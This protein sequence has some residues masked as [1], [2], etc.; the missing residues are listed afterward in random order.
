ML[1][2]APAKGDDGLYFVRVTNDDKKKC[3]VQLNKVKVTGISGAEV[4]IDPSSA[5]NK[6]KITAI[7]KQNLQAAKDN[8]VVWFGKDMT[9]DALKV[10]YSHAELVADRIPPTKVF[11]PDQ[12]VVDFSTLEL[13][14]E[15]SMILEYSG[16][17]FAK[18]AFGPAFNLVQVKIHPEPVRSEYPEE[19]AFVDEEEEQEPSPEPVMEVEP[20]VVEAENVDAPQEEATQE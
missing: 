10:A 2:N 3:F 11:S 6:K 20:E 12:E 8:A 17:W 18:K 13:G 5:S 1:Y 4:T 19:Y 15:C 7:D 9:A 16:M 14:R